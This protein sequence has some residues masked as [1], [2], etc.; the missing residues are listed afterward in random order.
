MI[1][2]KNTVILQQQISR[3]KKFIKL[4]KKNSI[5]SIKVAQCNTRDYR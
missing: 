5:N 3:K 4:Q 2:P 1:P